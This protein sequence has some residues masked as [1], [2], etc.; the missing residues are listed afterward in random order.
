MSRPGGPE[1]GG[2][3]ICNTLIYTSL[4][5]KTCYILTLLENISLSLHKHHYPPLLRHLCVNTCI[6]YSYTLVLQS[7]SYSFITHYFW[8]AVCRLERFG[9]KV[10]AATADGT[11][12]NR[13]L[14]GFPS[15]EMGLLD[16]CSLGP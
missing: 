15:L 3:K 16:E 14:A 7:F 4:Y 13:Q 2:V 5:Y 10:L 11:S 8:E 1:K 9:I 6:D 12:P